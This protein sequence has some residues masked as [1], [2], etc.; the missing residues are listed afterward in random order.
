MSFKI[1][2]QYKGKI[3]KKDL[4]KVFWRSIP[5]E[6]L[7]NYER[8]MNVGYTYAMIP[9]L[10]KLYPKKEDLSAALTRN[11]EVY[12]VTPYIITLPEGIAT[13]M[14]ELNASDPNF[15]TESISAVKLAMMGPLSGVGDAF[16]WGTLRIL[17]T[18]VGTSLALQGNILGP[19]LFLLIFDVP[20]FIIRYT[21]TFLGYGLGS[22]VIDKLKQ[23]GI[24]DKVMEYA[25]IMG[26]MV[27]GGMTMSMSKVNFVTKIGSGKGAQTIQN[28]LDGIAPGLA[29][30]A[31]FGIMYWMLKKKMN[32]LLIMLIVL[33]VSIAGAYF[34]VLGV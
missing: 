20:H 23:S 21:M 3:T 4:Q 13:A 7:W 27:V 15:D 31:L 34:N 26:I 28:L 22:N 16:F 19:I 9:I 5:T 18:G 33:I 24:M 29:T 8:M 30:L 1:Q 2:P 6:H 11:L 10:K 25:S 32:P 12:N 17:A 14:E